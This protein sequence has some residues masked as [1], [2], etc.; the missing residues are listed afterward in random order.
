MTLEEMGEKF[1]PIVQAL[2]LNK[3][4]MA[5]LDW[6]ARVTEPYTPPGDH[7][8]TTKMYDF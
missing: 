6:S 3:G 2:A 5:A 8:H 4:F 7:S 1:P